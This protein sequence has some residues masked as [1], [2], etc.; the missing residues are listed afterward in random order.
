MAILS[1]D[2]GTTG[3]TALIVGADARIL[4]RGYREFPQHFP[5]VGWV[6][7]DLGE[8]WS[9]TLARSRSAPSATARRMSRSL[10]IGLR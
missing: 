4:A 10:M 5:A 8:M 7:H 3:V 6:E 2:C 9:A 1:L